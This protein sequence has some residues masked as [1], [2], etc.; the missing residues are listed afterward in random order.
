VFGGAESGTFVKRA[1]TAQMIWASLV[2]AAWIVSVALLP[3]DPDYTSGELLDHVLAWAGGEPLYSDPAVAPYRVL[4]YPPTILALARGLSAL[5]LPVIAAGRL[6]GSAGVALALWAAY[7][8]MRDRGVEARPA[9]AVV[10]LAAASFPLMYAAG[11]FHLE[12]FALGATVLGYRL[13]DRGDRRSAAY[14]GIALAM[15]C[16][17]KQSQVVPALIGLAWLAVRGRPGAGLAATTFVASGIVGSAVITAA[18]GPMAWR[19][20]LTYTVGTYSLLNLASQFAQHV[21]PW[22]PVAL[23]GAWSIGRYD[24]ARRDLSTWYFVGAT[25][26][27]FSAARVGSGFPYFLDWHFASL[28]CCAPV[29]AGWL[30]TEVAPARKRPAGVWVL[31][32]VAADLAVAVVLAANVYRGVLTSRALD[33]LCP[34]I[35]AAPAVTVAESAGAIRACGG[36]PV[37]HAFITANLTRRGL[38]AEEPYVRDLRAGAYRVALLDFDPALGAVGVHQ[39]RWTPATVAALGEWRTVREEHGWR[40]LVPV[41]RPGLRR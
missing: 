11:Q 30:R 35:P 40:V 25:L 28:I 29:V 26:W 3:V 2:G 15:A 12:G 4:N 21:L 31:P 9:L 32:I 7:G 1:T 6:L 19:H 16:L 17:F 34:L 13:A 10:S 22:I 23:L 27:M 20:M 14:A 41:S 36:R 5:G 39:D 38:W 33:A 8:W 24:P 37:A 18:F